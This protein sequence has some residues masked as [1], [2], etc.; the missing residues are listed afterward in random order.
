ML[1]RT[2]VLVIEGDKAIR[3]LKELNVESGDVLVIEPGTA[4]DSFTI[5]KKRDSWLD[6]FELASQRY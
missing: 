6:L 5:P 2:D 4:S 1:Y 3:L